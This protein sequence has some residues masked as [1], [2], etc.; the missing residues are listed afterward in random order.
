MEPSQAVTPRV[1]PLSIR[2]SVALDEK[3]RAYRR[4]SRKLYARNVSRVEAARHLMVLGLKTLGSELDEFL[5][6]R[7]TSS[8]D[9]G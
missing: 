2:I 4:R 3:I 1:S 9:E 5:Y 6:S 7:E 8:R